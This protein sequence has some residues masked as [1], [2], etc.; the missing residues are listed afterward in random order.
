MNSYF[1]NVEYVDGIKRAQKEED[2]NTSIQSRW[3]P[4]E[5]VPTEIK[6][7]PVVFYID[8]ADGNTINSFE[9]GRDA[10]KTLHAI[11]CPKGYSI[12]AYA[13]TEEEYAQDLRNEKA[14]T[15]FSRTGTHSPLNK[16]Y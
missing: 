13:P 6:K 1:E 16:E 8:D 14:E 3:V 4:E 11:G 12:R 10:V 5:Y 2:H 7:P 9:D 15:T